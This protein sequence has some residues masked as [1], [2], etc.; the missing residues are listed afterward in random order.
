MEIAAFFRRLPEVYMI[1]ISPSLL[2]ADFSRLDRELERVSSADALH[3]D[4]MDGVFVPNLS[5]GPPVL[6]SLRKITPL[7]FDVHL[8]ITRPLDYIENFVKC[9]ADCITFHLESASDPAETIRCI[10]SFGKQAGLSIKPGTA[11]EALLPFLG[12]LD[13]VLVMS[14]EPGFGGQKFMPSALPK[15]K[16]LREAAPSM[17]INVD[18]GI[19]AETG[20]LCVEAGADMLV[21]GSYVFGAADSACAIASLRG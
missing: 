11:P 21:A 15:I 8:M 5:F 16:F 9:G 12:S 6:Q 7:F 3:L 18:G 13:M 17:T 14:V 19:N 1:R 2:A 4:V 20:R 10:H